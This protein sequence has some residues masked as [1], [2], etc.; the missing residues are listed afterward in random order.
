MYLWV[1]W[2]YIFLCFVVFLT[3]KQKWVCCYCHCFVCV[4]R[5]VVRLWNALDWH[6]QG[7]QTSLSIWRCKTSL[8]PLHSS[9]GRWS[10][11]PESPQRAFIWWA[12]SSSQLCVEQ[13]D[14]PIKGWLATTNTCSVESLYGIYAYIIYIY[15]RRFLVAMG[16]LWMAT[17]CSGL[18]SANLTMSIPR[19]P[20]STTPSS[21][22]SPLLPPTRPEPRSEDNFVVVSSTHCAYYIAL[23][24]WIQLDLHIYVEMM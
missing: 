12:H 23:M 17:R 4:H 19:L 5:Q 9:S 2:W 22:S 7:N 21:R 10:E 1:I 18:Q 6:R 15:I 16:V 14:F 20:S 3:N 24:C 13:D 8:P 11:P